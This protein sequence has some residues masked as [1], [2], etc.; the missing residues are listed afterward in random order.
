M[1]KD[2]G[3]LDEPASAPKITTNADAS[4]TSPK[5]SH[6][7]HHTENRNMGSRDDP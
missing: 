2:C 6:L 7:D 1:S 3:V 5:H 4:R